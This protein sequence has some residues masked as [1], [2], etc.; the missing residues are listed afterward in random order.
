MARPRPLSSAPNALL[1]G[2]RGVLV[3]FD[4]TLTTDGRFTAAA[5]AALE[6]LH[7]S[8]LFL[9]IVTG[10]PAGFGAGLARA[11]PIDACVAEGGGVTYLR[12]ADGRVLELPYRA[13]VTARRR[14]RAAVLKAARATAARHGA[15]LS[16]DLP[17]RKVDVAIDWNEEAR[18]PVA[19]A[20]AM[21]RE[22]RAEGLSVARSS[23]HVNVW[24]PG[25]DKATACR[26]L[27]AAALG[28]NLPEEAHRF[29]YVGDAPNDAPAFAAFP[30]TSVGVADV[31]AALPELQ[32]PP[33]YVTR[34]AGAEG[35]CEAAARVLLARSES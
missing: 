24:P 31:L 5:L 18:L 27:L 23:V 35:F 10:R 33:K 6:A 26:S 14:A 13:E 28:A 7:E 20:R 29:L 30:A 9:A 16:E 3:D 21:E 32:T 4:G 22:L 12:R 19:T 11:L 2:L 8:G 1:A 34:S 15:K 17:F 25:F